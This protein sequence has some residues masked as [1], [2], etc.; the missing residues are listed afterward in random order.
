M[1]QNMSLITAI[2]LIVIGPPLAIGLH[3]W[4]AFVASQIWLDMVARFGWH[5]FTTVEF[6]VAALVIS[7][8]RGPNLLLVDRRSHW[9]DIVSFVGAPAIAWLMA[10]AILFLL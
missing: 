1:K 2:A 3:L 8:A 5:A 7:C 10:K 4:G 6:A 9:K